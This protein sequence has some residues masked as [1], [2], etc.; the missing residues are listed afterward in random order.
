MSCATT[1]E[2]ARA[3]LATCLRSL[4]QANLEEATVCVSVPFSLAAWLHFRWPHS[5]R[6]I[7]TDPCDLGFEVTDRFN[8]SI[9]SDRR[10]EIFILLAPQSLSS[11]TAVAP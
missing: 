2:A 9:Q 1:Q 5:T 8:S 7:A 3:P 11:R 6:A 4:D 10:A